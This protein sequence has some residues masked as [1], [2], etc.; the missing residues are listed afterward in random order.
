MDYLSVL[1]AAIAAFAVGALWYGPLFGKPWRH[2]MGVSETPSKQMMVRSMVG[3]FL[4]TVVLV[5]VLAVVMEAFA[6]SSAF[7]AAWLGALLSVGFIATV[8]LNSVWYEGRPWK[9]YAI[10]ASHYLVALI[11]AALVLL[12]A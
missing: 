9:L 8:L 4:S 11:V 12:Y 3:G 6:I 7:R 1:L 5:Y 10:N 2:L